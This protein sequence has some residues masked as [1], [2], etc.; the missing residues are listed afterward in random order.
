M[1]RDSS[2]HGWIKKDYETEM[3]LLWADGAAEKK[4]P[5]CCWGEIIPKCASFFPAF[6][7]L[8]GII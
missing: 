3:K 2:R 7:L 8:P 1:I 6:P 5:N 4:P